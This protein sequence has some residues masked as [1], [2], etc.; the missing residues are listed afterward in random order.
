MPALTAHFF[1]MKKILVAFSVLV[2]FTSFA[3]SPVAARLS[4][5]YDIGM[6]YST[7]H[8]NPS[9]SY[10]QLLTVSEQKLFSFGWNLRLGA[11]YGD[12]LD[13]YTA[14]ARLTR[15]KSGL[16][17]IGLPLM[18]ANMDTVRF[19]H[20]SMTSLSVGVRAKVNLGRVELGASADL[21]G[22]TFGKSRTGQY[23]SSTGQFAIQSAS[24]ADSLL[25]PFQGANALQKSSPGNFNARLLGDNNRGTLST[26]VYAHI[27][28]T[29]R[30]GIKLGYQW[31]IT[32]M[33]VAKRDVVADNNRFRNRAGMAYLALSLPIFQ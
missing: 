9:I 15:G 20:V 29:Q 12:N 1:C 3:Q 32:E 31:L 2:S 25:V 22:F 11:F 8:Y 18:P 24:G 21:L 6:A 17:S 26:Q 33:S 10:Y 28:L 13:Y 4:S 14:P 19:D 23:Q 16:G 5:G 30:V 7:G 27:R